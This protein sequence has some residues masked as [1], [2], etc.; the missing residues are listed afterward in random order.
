MHILQPKH[1]KLNQKEAE[2]LLKKF[3]IVR[4]QLPRVLSN[5]PCLPDG[6]EVGDIVKIERKS[7]G[8]T[9]VYFRVVVE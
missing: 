6:C 1:S 5:D 2:E 7:D 9:E 8:K 4:A 3:N